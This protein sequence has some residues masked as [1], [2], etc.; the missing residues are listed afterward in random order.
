[1]EKKTYYVSL[2]QGEISQVPTDETTFILTATAEEISYLRK[3][4]QD[5][6]TYDKVSYW[7]SHIPFLEYHYDEGNDG[8]DQALKT[9]YAHMYQL[10]ND[11]TKKCIEEMGILKGR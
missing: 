5:M 8:Y 1:M 9:A 7:R 4:F 11:E 2:T 10:G 3:V 6:Y